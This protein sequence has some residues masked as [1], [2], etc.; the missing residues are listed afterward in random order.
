M[1]FKGEVGRY[2]CGHA[3][4]GNLTAYQVKDPNRI[5]QATSRT[6]PPDVI[7]LPESLP[8][9]PD[10]PREA[11][12]PTPPAVQPHG[13]LSTT[14]FQSVEANKTPNDGLEVRSTTQ[15]GRPGETLRTT[16]F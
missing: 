4:D 15:A 8:K 5:E 9:L 11:A 2:E 12:Q 1:T 16:D 13:T 10:P 6:H 14:D 7:R 3:A